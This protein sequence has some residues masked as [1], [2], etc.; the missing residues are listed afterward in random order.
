M[1]AID[2]SM[3]GSEVAAEAYLLCCKQICL[4]PIHFGRVDCFEAT[5]GAKQ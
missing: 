5:T 2:A 4:I 1:T 3:C